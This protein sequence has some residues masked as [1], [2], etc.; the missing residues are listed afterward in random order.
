MKTV[1]FKKLNV[2]LLILLHKYRPYENYIT[3][4]NINAQQ[5]YNTKTRK[6]YFIDNFCKIINN[7]QT[8]II[9]EPLRPELNETFIWLLKS[10]I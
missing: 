7:K 1:T 2:F 10:Y 5:L 6:N 8:Y 3:S 9:H 4:S